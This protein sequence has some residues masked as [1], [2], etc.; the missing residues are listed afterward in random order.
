VDENPERCDHD[1]SE[2][3]RKMGSF[4]IL[5]I[6]VVASVAI[7]GGSATASPVAT[8]KKHANLQRLARGLVKAGAPGALVYVRTP[9]GVRSAA[10][11]FA[12]LAP[13]ATMRTSHR[14]R[15]ASVTKTFVSTVVLLLEAEGKLRVDDS[16]E[17][18]LPGLVPNG[19]SISLRE[20]LNHTSGL[21]DYNEDQQFGAAILA[22]P[23]RQWAPREL[24]AFAL[25]HSALFAPGTNW[26]YSNTNYILL[27]L[28][29]EAVTGHKLAGELQTRIL[30]PLALGA[31]SFPTGISIDGSFAHGYVRLAPGGDLIDTTPVLDPSFSWAAGGIVS[32]AGD[33]TKFFSS[34]LKGRLLPA[35]QLKE[36]KTGSRVSGVYGLGLRMTTTKC[37]RV[38]GH[39]GAFPGYRT[40]VWA[41]SN[42]RRVAVV[43]INTNQ[44]LPA[45]SKLQPAAVTALCSG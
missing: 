16:V 29:I 9:T 6:G 25:A 35:A 34:L 20:L 18:W 13:R 24:L 36:M 12:N 32:N 26:S 43:M 41:T 40:I 38:F 7:C 10:A 1:R 33:L 17:R 21:F 4:R 15:V 5:V 22:N 30:G 28:V 39:D 3:G 45:L 42:G 31:T 14:Y 27:G 11:G 23:G 2:K 44:G 8:P 37:G 19:T